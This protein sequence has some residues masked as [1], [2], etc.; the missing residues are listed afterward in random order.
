[1]DKR[2]GEFQAEDGIDQV[3]QSYK[4]YGLHKQGN[5]YVYQEWAPEARSISIFGEFNNWNRG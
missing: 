1:M 2:L 3:S 4:K 5:K